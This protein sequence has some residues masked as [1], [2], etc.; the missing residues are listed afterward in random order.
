MN[1]NELL[2]LKKKLTYEKKAIQAKEKKLNKRMKAVDERIIELFI[3]EGT[4]NIKLSGGETVSLV[5]T[6]RYSLFADTT[7]EFYKQVLEDPSG[8]FI[9]LISIHHSSMKAFLKSKKNTIP[10]G[11]E[12]YFNEYEDRIIRLTGLK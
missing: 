10:E 2:E 3:D 4:Q 7:P 8:D 11:F 1:Q 12:K 5:K 6:M 9:K